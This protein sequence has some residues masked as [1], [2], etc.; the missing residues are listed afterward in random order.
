MFLWVG[1]LVA[2]AGISSCLSPTLP[3]PPPDEPSSIQAASEPGHW[4]IRGNCTAGAMV[5]I[6]NER[7]GII[8]GTEDR[9]HL[10]RYEI[11]L[12]AERC[13]VATVFEAFDDTFT[14][15]TSFLVRE[16][17]GGVPTED[18]SDGGI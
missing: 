8:T 12:P 17:T 7:T 10:G 9:D 5:L 1:V 14:Q 4:E 18:C 13:D 3:L 2:A 16:V 6:R 11:L 15:G